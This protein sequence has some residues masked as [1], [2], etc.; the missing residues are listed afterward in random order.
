MTNG[1]ES[2]VETKKKKLYSY[3]T[4]ISSELEL[5]ILGLPNRS[6]ELESLLK[7]TK[8]TN[9]YNAGQGKKYMIINEDNQFMV[10]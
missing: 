8:I 5:L 4:V 3:V 6:S 10:I 7:S 9:S 2:H 1:Y